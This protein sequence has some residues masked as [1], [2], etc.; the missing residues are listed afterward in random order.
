MMAPASGFYTDPALGAKQV[1]LAYVL[2][3]GKL[4]QA[5]R[6]LAAALDAYPGTQR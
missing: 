4:Q 3:V 1:R 5:L 6:V 2:E